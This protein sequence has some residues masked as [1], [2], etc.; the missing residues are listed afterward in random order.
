MNFNKKYFNKNN[1]NI[2]SIEYIDIN[3]MQ[4]IQL[5]DPGFNNNLREKQFK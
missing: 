5:P 3:I 2:Y 4:T 1:I